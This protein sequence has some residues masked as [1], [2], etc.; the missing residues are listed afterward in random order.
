LVE[1]AIRWVNSEE[2]HHWAQRR[3]AGDL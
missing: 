1:N 3:N 2:A